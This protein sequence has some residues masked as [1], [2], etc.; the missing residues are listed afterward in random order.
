MNIDRNEISVIKAPLYEQMSGKVIFMPKWQRTYDWKPSTAHKMIQEIL[1]CAAAPANKRVNNT[2]YLGLTTIYHD[3]DQNRCV[4]AD[5]H[6]RMI[7]F[8]LIF[9]ALHDLC[10]TNGY[11]V[12]VPVPFGISYEFNI[13]NAEYEKFRK[14]PSSATKYGK[15]YAYAYECLEKFISDENRARSVLDAMEHYVDMAFETCDSLDLAHKCFVQLNT[16]GE[17]LTEVEVIS[18]FLQFYM[19]YHGVELQYEYKDLSS[20]LEGYYYWKSCHNIAPSFDIGVITNFLETEVVNSR[21]NMIEFGKYLDNINRY[22]DTAWFKLSKILGKKTMAITYV[23]AGRGYDMSGKDDKVNRLMTSIAVLDISCFACE[24]KMGG[25]LSGY[26]CEVRKQ[27]GCGMDLDLVDA[28]LKIWAG[29]NNFRYGDTFK[30]F[31]KGLDNLTDDRQKAILWLVYM[32]NNQ[33]SLPI[34]IEMDHCYPENHNLAWNLPGWPT[35]A[36]S[37]RRM[38]GSLGN[39]VLLDATTNKLVSNAGINDKEVYYG[40][41]FAHNAAYAN[42][43]NYFDIAQFKI[44]AQKYLDERRDAF[45][46]FLADTPMG[47]VLIEK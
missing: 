24:A 33:N 29:E 1:A 6:S 32:H 13:A 34:N 43:I 44:S 23:L 35:T 38:V 9:K 3:K 37:Q 2:A 20:L 41:F 12:L 18:S 11:N 7:S 16:G 8:A 4:I 46:R 31:A 26:F 42:T 22:K 5:G 39:K 30:E 10:E 27:I 47:Q 36:N 25:T 19:D 15:V 45:A 28:A 17:N 14:N 40:A 21:G